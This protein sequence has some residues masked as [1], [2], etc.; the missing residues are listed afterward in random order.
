[1]RGA[2][3]LRVAE[4]P[5]CALVEVAERPAEREEPQFAE[6]RGCVCDLR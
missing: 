5:G 6:E 4:T 1:M 3:F 2:P